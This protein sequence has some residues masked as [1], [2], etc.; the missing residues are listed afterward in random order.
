MMSN[1]SITC[2]DAVADDGGWGM[3]ASFFLG[4]RVLI[5]QWQWSVL[6]LHDV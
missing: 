3:S 1:G 2:I 5:Q 6:S 4:G